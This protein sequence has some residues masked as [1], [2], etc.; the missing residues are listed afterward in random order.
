MNLQK[1][2]EVFTTETQNGFRKG[3][4]CTDTIFCLNSLNAQLIPI[5]HLLALLVAHHI[6][7]VSREKFKLLIFKKR[8]KFNLETHLLFIDYE[9]E[10]DNIQTQISVNILKSRQIPDTLLKA[11]V[12]SEMCRPLC[13]YKFIGRG[14]KSTGDRGSTVVKVLWYKSEGCWFDPSWCQWI[15]H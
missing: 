10:F 9:K 11:I 13:V 5:C 6:L 14:I 4:S 7:H 12:D 2:S 3:R 1:Y 8:R 15:F